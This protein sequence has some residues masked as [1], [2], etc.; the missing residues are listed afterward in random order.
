MLA[1][2]VSGNVEVSRALVTEHKADLLAQCADKNTVTG[3]DAGC[4]LLHGSMSCCASKHG[5]MLAFLLD[6]GGDIN[7]QSKAGL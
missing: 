2:V 6:S 7:A 5:D 3:F 1:A 4:G